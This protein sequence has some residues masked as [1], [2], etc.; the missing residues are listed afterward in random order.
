MKTKITR[1]SRYLAI[2]AIALITL[3]AC[4]KDDDKDEP[5]DYVGQWITVRTVE[6]EEGDIEIQDVINFTQ[7]GFTE[8]ASIIDPFTEEWV[9]LIGRKGE[10]TV[11]SG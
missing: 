3:Y 4:K 5:R 9:D 8:V 6:T 11:K 7:N 2:A 1:Y 10:F